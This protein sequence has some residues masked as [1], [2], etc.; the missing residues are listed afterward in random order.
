MKKKIV[1]LAIA[2]GLSLLCTFHAFAGW[3]QDENGWWYSKEDGSGGYAVGDTLIDGIYY[4]F[5]D[6]GYM[7]TGWRNKQ[8]RWY[9][10]EADGK[11]A[12]GWRQID[13]KWYYF[14][15][16]GNMHTGWLDLDG[17]RY[18]LENDGMVIGEFE[19]NNCLY[20]AD[21][22]G[23]IYRN[24]SLDKNLKYNEEGILVY[25]SK[26]TGKEWEPVAGDQRLSEE[27]QRNLY[28]KYVRE[29]G[30]SNRGE[31]ETAARKQLDGLL[32]EEE[33]EEF[34][35]YVEEDYDVKNGKESGHY[36]SSYT[37]YDVH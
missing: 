36:Y 4:W 25:R 24:K 2:A 26:N 28:D 32:S 15:G 6:S 1:S 19:L 30:F 37:D 5:N 29:K 8:G 17:N 7:Q 11:R 9:Y 14:T 12:E 31:F 20:F 21:E 3:Q 10:Y 22:T 34:I 23:A 16:E 13:G 33:I 35:D 18:F 27:V